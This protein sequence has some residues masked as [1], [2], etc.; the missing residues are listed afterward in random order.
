M[1]CEVG[2]GDETRL[3]RAGQGQARPL[4]LGMVEQ[5]KDRR[6]R[7][8]LESATRRL[9]TRSA[10]KPASRHTRAA[11][12]ASVGA[13]PERGLYGVSAVTHL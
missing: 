5:C 13:L 3:A 4:G 1:P 7:W 11:L 6:R 12:R 10:S 8:S 2:P 9:A